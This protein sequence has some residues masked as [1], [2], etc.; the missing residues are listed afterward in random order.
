MARQ[1]EERVNYRGE[2]RFLLRFIEALEIDKRHDPDWVREAIAFVKHLQ[3]H[4][5]MA[6]EH[7][8]TSFPK[9]AEEEKK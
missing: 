5:H 8:K 3:M 2:S 7:I 9:L 6:D 1:V 4:L